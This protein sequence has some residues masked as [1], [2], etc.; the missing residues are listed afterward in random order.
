MNIKIVQTLNDTLHVALWLITLTNYILYKIFLYFYPPYR[1][2]RFPCSMAQKTPISCDSLFMHGR[3]MASKVNSL[4]PC[5]AHCAQQHA[6]FKNKKVCLKYFV[7]LLFND[8]SIITE[9][10]WCTQTSWLYTKLTFPFLCEGSYFAMVAPFYR[11]NI[12]NIHINLTFNPPKGFD[13]V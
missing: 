10:D 9:I 11:G 8:V 7:L 12:S 6:L 13:F 2:P 4:G 3:S 1:R 5:G